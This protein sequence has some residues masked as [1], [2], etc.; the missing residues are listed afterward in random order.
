MS[1]SRFPPDGVL[2]R[3]G[4][5]HRKC[6]W[7]IG[8]GA[9]LSTTLRKREQVNAPVVNQLIGSVSGADL[10]RTPAADRGKHDI[11]LPEVGIGFCLYPRATGKILDA[12]NPV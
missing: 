11:C 3:S 12:V 4:L 10:V 8:S 5:L 1:S 9:L 6:N 7:R 2:Q